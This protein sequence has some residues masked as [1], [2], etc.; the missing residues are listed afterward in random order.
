MKFSK[1]KRMISTLCMLLALVFL[2]AS[3]GTATPAE[4]STP[5]SSE[6]SEAVSESAPAKVA[7]TSEFVT[8]DF[9]VMGDAPTNGQ[10]DAVTAK[11]NEYLKDKINANIKF[12]WTG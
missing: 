12:R 7:D 8:I 5:A 2:M 11:M 6:A 10:I 9:Q 3:C 1:K 4:S